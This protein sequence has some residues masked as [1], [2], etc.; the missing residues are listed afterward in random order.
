M[1]FEPDMTEGVTVELAA[2]NLPGTP[3][4]NP[5]MIVLRMPLETDPYKTVLYTVEAR[6]KTGTYDSRWP[7]MRSSSTGSSRAWPSA[8]TPTTL[9]RPSPT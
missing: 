4:E 1:I 6:F 7:A 2:A 5:Q 8:W 3:A 9:R